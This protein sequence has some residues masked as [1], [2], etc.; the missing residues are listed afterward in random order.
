MEPGELVAGRFEVERIAGQGGMGD[1]FRAFDRHARA[2]VALKVLR[3]QAA[4]EA[5][6][7]LREGA[8]LAEI[9]HPGIVRYVAHGRTAAGHPYLAMEW[10]EGHDLDAHLR[11]GK[12]SAAES[13]ALAVRVAQALGAAHARGV[14]HRDVK[15][16]NIFLVDG[17]AD[18]VRVLD[19]GIAQRGQAAQR[20]TRTGMILGTPAYMAP[21][22]ARACPGSC[23]C[24]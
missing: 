16:S 23:R 9:S 2:F 13:V 6:R 24:A 22:Q 3:A 18:R 21:E 10:L 14:I 19:F 12:L 15:P 4:S 17:R 5:E 8:V 20:V 1:V 11:G 7:F